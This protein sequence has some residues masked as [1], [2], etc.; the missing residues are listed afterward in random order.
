MTT[1]L[2][3]GIA[4]AA[5]ALF[6]ISLY[7][8]LTDTD[9]PGQ[10]RPDDPTRSASAGAP[11]PTALA[12]TASGPRGAESGSE[13]L[14]EDQARLAN[15]RILRPATAGGQASSSGGDA[16]AAQEPDNDAPAKASPV[17]EAGANKPFPGFVSDKSLWI[18]VLDQETR[19][20]VDGALVILRPA[21]MPGHS[22]F[23][24]RAENGRLLL[25]SVREGPHEFDVHA[26]GYIAFDCALLTE[27]G[28]RT[29]RIELD[30][31]AIERGLTVT[32]IRGTALTGQV[33]DADL[34]P[35]EAMVSVLS[36]DELPMRVAQIRTKGGAFKFPGLGAGRFRIYAKAAGH[37]PAFALVDIRNGGVPRALTMTLGKR[38]DVRVV[39][40]DDQGQPIRGARIEA[41]PATEQGPSLKSSTGF[42]WHEGRRAIAQADESG[43]YALPGLA[44]GKVDMIVM[45]AGYQGAIRLGVE[46]PGADSEALAFRLS[47]GGSLAGR[48]LDSRGKPAKGCWVSLRRGFLDFDAP[49]T[50]ATGRF[51]FDG[52]PPG[53]YELVA[54]SRAGEKATIGAV[55]AREAELTVNL[56]SGLRVFGR[57]ET[58]PGAPEISVIACYNA[59]ERKASVAPGGAFTMTHREPEPK[60]LTFV[61]EGY[62]P[63]TIKS[64]KVTPGKPLEVV[65]K[66]R[67][68]AA[69]SGTVYDSEGRPA[70]SVRIRAIY[71][72][73]DRWSEIG[74]D[75][76]GRFRFEELEAGPLTIE[77]RWSDKGKEKVSRLPLEVFAGM[78]I[79]DLV[80]RL[81]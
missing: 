17:K 25:E 19:K 67:L 62:L 40:T 78:E 8:P 42:D 73:D 5:L 50:D 52:L 7:G 29:T 27:P 66:L 39:V 81:E 49:E 68:A 59:L 58:P 74:T 6:G 2:K 79:K 64:P 4:L 45:A 21:N 51:R 35:I 60:S 70:G 3:A 12:L 41:V 16:A 24:Q 14:L 33:R 61:A 77:V 15:R 32:L 36:D 69:A 20:P 44:P 76:F 53:P 10:R 46:V 31:E 63:T 38:L 28:T 26:D 71:T 72:K 22:P 23:Y 11:D 56:A 30:A 43:G 9:Q 18:T 65:V 75:S 48:A 57:V 55:E 54:H 1:K 13:R 47:P 34:N 37:P 80:L